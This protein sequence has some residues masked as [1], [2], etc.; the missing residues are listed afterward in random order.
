MDFLPNRC[1]GLTVRSTSLSPAASPVSEPGALRYHFVRLALGV[2]LRCY[3]RIQPEGFERLPRQPYLICFN[4]LNWIDPFLLTALWPG[5]A[6]LFIYGPRE[7]DLRVGARNRIIGWS[8]RAVP[9]RPGREDLRTSAARAVAVLARGDILAIAG[10]GR[11]S[12]EEDV[13]LPIQPGAAYFALRAQVPIVPVA[14][15]GARWLRFGKRIR[16]RVGAPIE[17]PAPRPTRRAV[18]DLTES[19]Q[20]ALNTMV[21][22]YTDPRIPGPFGRWVTDLFNE[23]PWL[24][25]PGEDQSR[26]PVPPSSS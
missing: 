7:D 11:L 23:R 4:H 14:I 21:R 20:G 13:V 3:L 18:A 2:L 5:P 8:R 9:F 12:E 25:E 17:P 16:V 10:E 6:R 1:Y 24:T 26:D 22:D 15:N 19:V